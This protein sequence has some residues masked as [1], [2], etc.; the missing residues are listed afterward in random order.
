[1]FESLNL[2]LNNMK[3]TGN[4]LSPLKQWT[5]L[6]LKEK[7]WNKQNLSLAISFLFTLFPWSYNT[8]VSLT[9]QKPHT[10][11]PTGL[12]PGKAVAMKFSLVFAHPT[13]TPLVLHLQLIDKSWEAG[14]SERV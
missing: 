7:L 6:I 12:L 1:M 3:I 10:I 11:G 4:L 8:H 5:E 13:T 14:T 2:G 9:I